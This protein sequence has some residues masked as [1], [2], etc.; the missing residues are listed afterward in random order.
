MNR[1]IAALHR[2]DVAA[3]GLPGLRQ[4]RQLLA[5]Q[6][7]RWSKQYQLSETDKIPRWTG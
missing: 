4:A 1:V 6:I 3:V 2:V 7:S 5:R